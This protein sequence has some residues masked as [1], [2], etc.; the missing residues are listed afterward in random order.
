[1]LLNY[2]YRIAAEI[3]FR[4]SLVTAYR[5]KR[6]INLN[7]HSLGPVRLHIYKTESLLRR[8]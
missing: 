2:R 5:L 3:N 7:M 6:G 8:L 1:M 4:S